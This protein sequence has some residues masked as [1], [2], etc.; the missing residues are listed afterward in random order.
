MQIKNIREVFQKIRNLF[1][2]LII[3][4]IYFL[5]IN[6]EAI[7]NKNNERRIN[8]IDSDL[9]KRDKNNSY[10]NISIQDDSKLIAIPIIPFK[11]E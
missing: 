7:K 10:S 3:I 4:I 1:P 9:K 6:V 11:V 2:Y 5:I 8:N